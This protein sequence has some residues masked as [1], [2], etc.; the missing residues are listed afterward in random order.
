VLGKLVYVKNKKTLPH[1]PGHWNEKKQLEV[2]TT[3]LALGNLAES[4]RVCNVPLITIKKW[5]A[6]PWWAELVS[7]IQSGEG[8]RADNKMSKTIDKALD[9]IMTRMEEGDYVYDQKT[10]RLVKVPLK[11]RDLERV[12]SGLFDKRQL[13]RKQPTSIKQSD[14]NQKDR[15]LELAEQFAK[16][17]GMKIEQEKVVNEYIEGDFN[18]LTGEDN[19]LHDQRQ[20]GLQEGVT[21]GTL[22]EEEQSEG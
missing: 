11:A 19:A 14:L 20:E 17:A 3:Y 12:A 2:V 6:Q 18:E 15:L 22:Q 10:G 1:Q 7:D 5:K 9:L 4:S 8:Q 13:I 16:F 21:M